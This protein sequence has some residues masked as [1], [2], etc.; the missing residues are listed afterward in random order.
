M[1]LLSTT[2]PGCARR[3]AQLE[4]RMIESRTADATGDRRDVHVAG[5]RQRLIEPDRTMQVSVGAL[6]GVAGHTHLAGARHGCA[7]GRGSGLQGR[8]EGG[9]LHDRAGQNR[10]I[11][12]GRRLCLGPL[13][14]EVDREPRQHGLGVQLG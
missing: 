4:Q 11:E 12:A 1:C 6:Q 10:H 3:Q 8:G 7:G 2:G 5:M 9:N 13:R 14:C